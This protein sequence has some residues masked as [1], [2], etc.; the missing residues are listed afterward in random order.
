MNERREHLFD[1]PATL[2]RELARRIAAE[3]GAAVRE[4]GE[5]SL[6]VSGGSTPQPLYTALSREPLL[7]ERMT[8]TVA[9][10][11]WVPPDDPASNQRLVRR[12]LLTGRAGKARWIGLRNAAP[13]PEE[14]LEECER[15][16]AAIA[17]PF[18]VVVL[19][20]GEDGHTASL[21]PAA[22]NLEAGLDPA[23]GRSCLPVRPPRAP[24]ARMSLTAATLLDSRRIVLHI[25]GAAKWAVYQRALEPGPAEEMP[26]RAF[27]RRAPLE[28]YWAP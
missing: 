13:T 3:L 21:F 12:F 11:R 5:A 9:D 8:V 27:L 24:H 15:A 1:D 23:A 10:E 7:W 14:G 26:I 4:R 25:T 18:D 19:G 22:A 6:V 2:A 20:M 16:L 28:I 17:R